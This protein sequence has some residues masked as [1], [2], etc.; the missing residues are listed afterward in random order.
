[1]KATWV[2]LINDKNINV[3]EFSRSSVNINFN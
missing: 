3:K 2:D 1:M